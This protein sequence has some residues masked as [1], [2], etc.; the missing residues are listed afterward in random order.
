MN[1]FILLISH[2]FDIWEE[3]RRQDLESD[4]HSALFIFEMYVNSIKKDKLIFNLKND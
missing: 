1:K 4:A 3:K 2:L